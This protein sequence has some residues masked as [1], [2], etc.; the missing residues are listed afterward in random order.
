MRTD[1]ASGKRAAGSSGSDGVP[2]Q[3]AR[4]NFPTEQALGIFEEFALFETDMGRQQVGKAKEY[5]TIGNFEF[6]HKALHGAM[7]DQGTRYG[8]SRAGS[9]QPRQE[10]DF[11][12]AE[13]RKQLGNENTTGM[14]A[15][16]HD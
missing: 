9:F 11:L 6:A 10:I 15:G 14:L 1:L 16:R 13:M 7:L 12:F 2:T 3:C 4:Q 8:G 5:L